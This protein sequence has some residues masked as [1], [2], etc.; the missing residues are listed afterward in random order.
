MLRLGPASL[1]SAADDEGDDDDVTVNSS[2]GV[3]D[4]GSTDE[5]GQKQAKGNFYH[6]STFHFQEFDKLIEAL[7]SIKSTP[8]R[9]CTNLVELHQNCF[10][11]IRGIYQHTFIYSNVELFFTYII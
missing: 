3:L 11:K 4:D 7:K 6:C 10:F 2:Q 5:S 8:N 9:N 1:G